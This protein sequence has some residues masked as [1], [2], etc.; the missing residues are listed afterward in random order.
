MTLGSINLL[1]KAMEITKIIEFSVADHPI[2]YKVII[3][4][5]WMNSKR[6]V[7]STYHLCL[8]FSTPSVG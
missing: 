3:V 4:T 1:V 8:K 7:P 6:V 2:V 5:A